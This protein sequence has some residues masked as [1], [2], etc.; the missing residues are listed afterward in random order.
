MTQPPYPPEPNP[1]SG[2]QQPG[3][4]PPPDY[5]QTPQYG[6]TPPPPPPPGPQYGQTPP[7]QPQY[8]QAPPPPPPPGPQYGQ[9]QGGYPGGPPPAGQ[10]GTDPTKVDVGEAFS[11]AWGK[12]KNNVGAMILPGVI[13]FALILIVTLLAVFA[14]AIF[15]TTETHTSDY[16]SGYTY[17]YETTTIG[18][19][20]LFLMFLLYLVLLVGIFY[21]QISIISGALRVANGEPVTSASFLKPTRFG[22]T[23][24]TA[25][26]VGIITSIGLVLCVIP[27]LIA[28]FLLQFSIVAT[29]DKQ[30]S[31][32]DAMKTSFELAKTKVGDSLIALLVAYAI[33]LVGAIVCYI[34]LIVSAPLA[35]LFYVH[36]W[37]RL[38]GAPIAP[39][40]PA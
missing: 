2:G 36:C 18:G 28:I 37:R 4:T 8:G 7:P 31:P 38:N 13:A 22:P 15:G 19:G 26:L 33:N 12:F 9:P 29:I 27:G 1:A 6:Q 11:W 32:V 39:P 3:Q 24:L 35:Q 30:L 21:I 10:F 34:G 16:G 17:S 25:I 40:D 23:I 5:G 14:T 20:G